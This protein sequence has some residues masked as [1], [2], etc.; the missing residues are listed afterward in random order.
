MTPAAIDGGDNSTV[1][2][3]R[4]NE[5]QPDVL[6]RQ[7]RKAGGKSII[8]ADGYIEGSPELIVE[9]AASTASNDLGDKLRSYRRNGVQEYIVWQVFEEKIDWFYLD[10][11][12]YVDLSTDTDGITRSQVFPGLWLDKKALI[13]SNM[14][15]V[16]DTL[17]QGLSSKEHQ[18]F[19]NQIRSLD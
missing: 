1:R 15:Q 11:D 10:N 16:I 7:D 14:Q 3:G 2:L 19:V 8:D 6:L 17:Q 13:E 4:D 5:P 18:T 9:I 12:E